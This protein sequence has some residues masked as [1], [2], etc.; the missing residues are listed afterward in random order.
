MD[1]ITV[2]Q[3][4]PDDEACFEHLEAIRWGD[5]PACPHCGS[6]DVARKNE[7]GRL[8]RWNCHDC[9]SSFN[10]LSGTIMSQ[11]RIPLQKWFLAITIITN[12]KKSISS[13]QLARDLDL[14]QRTALYL[15]QRIRAQMAD[16]SDDGLL[17][18]IV[19]ADESY[20]G[21]RHRRDPER[22]RGRGTTKV[23]VLGAVER[24][25]DVRTQVVD[26]VGGK[27]LVKFLGS[28]IDP[29]ASLLITDEFP[30]YRAIDRMMRRA[31]INHSLGHYSDGGI[32]HTNTIE[33]FWSL[34]KRAWYGTHHH[35]CRKFMPL[36]VAEQTWKYNHR[37]DLN[38]FGSFMA[39]MVAP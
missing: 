23:P 38:P 26:R 21:G 33:G 19:E 29:D 20:V 5:R 24:N 11:T 34:L 8:G 27:E 16:G 10:V 6:V 9:H 28:N 13:P 35:Y 18:G 7:R 37:H 36:Y 3:R 25:G 17:S 1:I 12:A 22:K 15:Q 2:F 32:V 14:T 30:A 31:S 4:F 39:A